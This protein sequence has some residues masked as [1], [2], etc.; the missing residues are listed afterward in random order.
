MWE[1]VSPCQ[2]TTL[3]GISRTRSKALTIKPQKPSFFRVRARRCVGASPEHSCRLAR[4]RCRGLSFN[5]MIMKQGA[6]ARI[7]QR[8]YVRIVGDESCRL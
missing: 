7:K 1:S 4:S 6:I 8:C 5:T 2:R 3:V